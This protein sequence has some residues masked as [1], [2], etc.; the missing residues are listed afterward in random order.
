MRLFLLATLLLQQP[1]AVPNPSTSAIVQQLTLFAQRMHDKQE[2]AILA[3]YTSD[4][5]FLDPEG[6]RFETPAQLRK[7]YDQVFATFDADL[8]F[9]PPSIDQRGHSFHTAG[10]YTETLTNRKTGE[11]QHLHGR[12]RINFSPFYDGHWAITRMQWL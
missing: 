1:A 11:V 9:D 10:T 3:S 6:H 12:Y 2:T 5:V 8:H 4:A 7:L